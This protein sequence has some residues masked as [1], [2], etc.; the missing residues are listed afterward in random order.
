MASWFSGYV[1][2]TSN[3]ERVLLLCVLHTPGNVL[4]LLIDVNWCIFLTYKTIFNTMY[5]C[6]YY[7]RIQWYTENLFTYTCNIKTLTS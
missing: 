5:Y 1:L 6:E 2:M 3:L 4:L 7:M